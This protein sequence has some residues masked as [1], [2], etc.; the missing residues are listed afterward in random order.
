MKKVIL[1]ALFLAVLPSVVQAQEEENTPENSFTL[2][3][4]LRPR[5]EYRNGAYIPLQEGEKPAILINNRTRLNFDYHHGDQLQL[6][7]SLQNVN[8]WGQ[9]PQV[10]LNDRTGGLSVFEA[11]AA[12]P[13][14]EDLNIKIG[15][16]MIVLDED[17]IFGSLDWHPAGRAHDAVNINW[18]NDKLTL[19]SFFA[20]NQNYFDGNASSVN[21]NVNNPKGQYFYIAPGTQPYQHLE[22]VHAHYDFAPTQGLSFLVA[23]LG[24]RNSSN[25]D[26]DYN[27]Q[28]IGFHYRGKSDALR[29]GAEAY[30]QT[31]KSAA[32]KDKEAFLLAALVG[33]Q[34]TPAFSATLGLDYLSGND[35]NDPTKDKAFNP[36]SG[37]NHKFYGFMDHFYVLPNSPKV[38]LLNPYLNLNLKTSD[39]GSL[40]FTGH[41]FRS[42]GK[43]AGTQDNKTRHLGVEGDLVYTHKIQQY[44]SLQ[45]GYSLFVPSSSYNDLRGLHNVRK[46]QDWLWC[47]LNINPKLFSAKF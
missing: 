11:Y 4:Q 18:K 45:A 25:N 36:F 9:A 42:A 31:G 20:F 24:Q 15:R 6:F 1:S 29:Y 41:Y 8:I 12:L 44:V 28:T 46:Q 21:G 47:S 5:F 17:R 3:A 26:I 27:M 22:A 43:I 35:A 7:V 19:R 30:L 38:G 39:K 32:G 13:I 14:Y 10:Q 37:T 2:S 33:Y 23:N 40:S 34:F 16:Q